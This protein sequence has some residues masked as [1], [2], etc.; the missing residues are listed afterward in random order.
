VFRGHYEHA[1]DA[2]GRTSVPSRFRDQ[3]ASDPL[4]H[5]GAAGELRIIVTSG[6]DPCL[7]VYPM[8]EWLAFE[9]KLSKLP[10]FDPSV[11]MIRRLYVSSAVEIEVDKL[12]RL[13]VP[14]ELREL[15][16]LEREALW[17]GMGDHLELWSKERFAAARN[18]AIAT[19][20]RRVE[21]SKRL[22]ELGL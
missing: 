4:S 16:G 6:V 14:K 1:I 21:I 8:K 12:G 9:E 15:A 22:A 3:L 5:A 2:K 13:L 19:E 20:E 17:A 18:A 10:K 7:L 11:V